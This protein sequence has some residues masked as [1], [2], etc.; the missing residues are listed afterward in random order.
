[1][2]P[3]KKTLFTNLCK[4]IGTILT[5]TGM[6]VGSAIFVVSSDASNKQFAIEQTNVVRQDVK[7]LVRAYYASKE[8]V[9][10]IQQ[11]LEDQARRIDEANQKLDKL[12]DRLIKAK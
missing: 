4:Y 8:D 3:K 10:K 11:K 7:S 6:V 1:M 5:V 9:A 12:I 2:T